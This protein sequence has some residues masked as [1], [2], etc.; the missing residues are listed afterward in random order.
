M[1][2]KF[3]IRIWKFSWITLQLS[4]C[5]SSVSMT[6]GGYPDT[7]TFI[8][9]IA[10]SRL[11]MENSLG[12]WPDGGA[13]LQLTSD[14]YISMTDPL[15]G[16]PSPNFVV[17]GS[18][19][20]AEADFFSGTGSVYCEARIGNTWSSASDVEAVY[21]GGGGTGETS[22][23]LVW[24][25]NAQGQPTGD[26]MYQNGAMYEGIYFEPDFTAPATQSPTVTSLGLVAR[27]LILIAACPVYLDLYDEQGNCVG[28]NAT[29]GTVENQI[30]TAVWESNQ[31]I[32]VFN[33]CGTYQLDVTGTGSGTCEL[34]TSWLDVTGTTVTILD[35]NST[36]TQG[37]TE[38]YLI[39]DSANLRLP[40]CHLPRPLSVRA[41]EPR[42]T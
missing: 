10:G 40:V 2:L 25:T 42:L 27:G 8:S 28:Y 29:S 33:P 13:D 31:T 15:G 22:K 16:Y 23:G 7:I 18:G 41:L 6:F 39:G 35:S 3:N 37:E 4:Q 12:S 1:V 26:F 11:S 19:N 9:N 32:L 5:L 20:G 14:A 21:Y 36:I 24:P 34:E 30:D 17:V 38:T